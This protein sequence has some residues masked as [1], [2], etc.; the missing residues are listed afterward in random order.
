GRGLGRAPVPS[1]SCPATCSR[2]SSGRLLMPRCCTP[3][4]RISTGGAS[5]PGAVGACDSRN[6]VPARKL[7]AV[8]CP[9]QPAVISTT[10]VSASRKLHDLTGPFACRLLLPGHH[11]HGLFLICKVARI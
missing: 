10:S 5:A 8:P 9:N 1:A 6:Q 2:A 7:R 4:S 3:A 11:R